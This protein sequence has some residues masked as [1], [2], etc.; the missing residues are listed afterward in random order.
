M[1]LQSKL[2]YIAIIAIT[3][4]LKFS[5]KSKSIALVYFIVKSDY[6]FKVLSI[7]VEGLRFNDKQRFATKIAIYCQNQQLF[8]CENYPKIPNLT[9]FNLQIGLS[10]QNA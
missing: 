10:L 8:F 6:P 9:L 5:N 4:Q 3:V 1:N 2:Q 7:T